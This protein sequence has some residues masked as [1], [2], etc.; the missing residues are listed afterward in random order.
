MV[1][2][3]NLKRK[4]ER[5]AN[6]ESKKVKKG[7]KPQPRISLGIGSYLAS[8]YAVIGLNETVTLEYIK[9]GLR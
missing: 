2:G 9:K 6:A 1:T 3:Q 5:V 7:F 8:K 4:M